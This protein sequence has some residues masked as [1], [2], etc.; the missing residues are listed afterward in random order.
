VLRRWWLDRK[1]EQTS[2]DKVHA[3]E[4]KRV[5]FRRLFHVLRVHLDHVLEEPVAA[6]TVPV[7]VVRGRDDVISTP[8]CGRRLAA[9]AAD[10]GYVEVPGPHSFCWRYPHRW[11][12]PI[13]KLRRTCG[14]SA[15]VVDGSRE[16]GD[17]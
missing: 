13:P 3:P 17:R 16:A 12:A 7:L 15:A 8:Q 6:L 1:R 5:G 2:P 10:G 11:S 4:R 9:L 14:R